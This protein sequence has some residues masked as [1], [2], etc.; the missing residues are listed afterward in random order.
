PTPATAPLPT[1]FYLPL[2][3]DEFRSTPATTSP[4]DETMQHGGPPAALLARAVGRVRP[5]EDMPIGRLTIDMVGPVPQGRIRT[6]AEIVRP[7]R[8]IELVEARLW[9]NDRLAVTA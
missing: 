4:W 7:G 5:G 3:A 9:A 1:A 6:E 2:A 8:R